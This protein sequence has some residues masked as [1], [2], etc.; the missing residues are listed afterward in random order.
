MKV[1]G[2]KWQVTG[3]V[4]RHVTRHL[5]PVT[6]H[7]SAFTLIEVLIAVGILALVMTAIYASWAAV[8]RA[9]KVGNTAADEVQRMRIARQAVEQSLAS[10]VLYAGNPRYYSFIADTTDEKFALLSFV[11]HLPQ[12][13]P[14]SGMF[15]N[16]PLRRVTF[17]VEPGTNSGPPALVL[18]QTSLLTPTNAPVEESY[19]LTLSR[20][21]AIFGV[22]FWST[23][24]NDW[25]VEWL[26]TNQ[27]PKMMRV[28]LGFGG[29]QRGGAAPAILVSSVISPGGQGVLR[30]LQT[31]GAPPGAGLGRPT[32]G[33]VVIPGQPGGGIP[34]T[35][36]PGIQ[37]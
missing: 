19:T 35:L 37:K 29:G 36:P 28:T 23:N 30:E 9:S 24:L 18:R 7:L 11:A 22:E 3:G 25:D 34:I 16:Q 33:T 32:P 4:R 21:L 10:A 2:D 17:A 31:A 15:P 6:R 5:S 20:H 12:D 26:A 13:F 14:G 8:L 1:A 27:V